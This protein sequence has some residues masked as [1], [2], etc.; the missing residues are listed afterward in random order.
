[1][2]I[3]VNRNEW[4]KLF[5]PFD[6]VISNI[7]MNQHVFGKNKDKFNETASDSY[8]DKLLGAQACAIHGH[9]S[10][11]EKGL[12]AYMD[13][14]TS[15]RFVN[16]IYDMGKLSHDTDKSV[17]KVFT[18]AL[19]NFNNLGESD[20]AT[21]A[22]NAAAN[23][24][25]DKTSESYIMVQQFLKGRGITNVTPEEL[26]LL[27]KTLG[28][29]IDQLLEECNRTL[30]N[31]ALD[32]RSLIDG[33]TSDMPMTSSGTFSVQE[34]A[35][36][37]K[38]SDESVEW[39]INTNLDPSTLTAQYACGDSYDPS[40][41]D[42]LNALNTG[43]CMKT[44]SEELNQIIEDLI[45]TYTTPDMTQAEKAFVCC[46]YMAKTCT[47]T[48]S[49]AYSGELASRDLGLWDSAQ[50]LVDNGTCANLEEAKIYIENK[51]AT[52]RAM[53]VLDGSISKGACQNYATA[54]AAC[55]RYLGFDAHVTAGRWGSKGGADNHYWTEIVD[56]DGNVHV[57]DTDVAVSGSGSMLSAFDTTPEASNHWTH[58]SFVDNEDGRTI[59]DYTYLFGT[60]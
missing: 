25:F 27:A 19:S 14:L 55:L 46:Q 23:D 6:L 47:H 9:L 16:S 58:D 39:G 31:S 56:A 10:V 8:T 43:V 40:M 51:H 36:T 7:G 38:Y 4:N 2:S 32:L 12:N 50:S 33:V 3:Y 49:G 28:I 44:S 15:H 45:N 59:H 13:A 5:G 11:Y 37:S 41:F 30:T 48:L 17:S 22:A 53:S 54:T 42:S 35:A 29:P 18:T 21:T 60:N 20:F 57:F 34:L 26:L 52:G 1:M 24:V